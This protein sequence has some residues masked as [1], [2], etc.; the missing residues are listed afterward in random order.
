[1]TVALLYRCTSPA[2]Q[3]IRPRASTALPHAHDSSHAL[4]RSLCATAILISSSDCRS[5]TDV[6]G[7][8][9]SQ[10]PEC[11]DDAANSLALSM[12]VDWHATRPLVHVAQ[13]PIVPCSLDVCR[14]GTCRGFW[15]LDK[16]VHY[17]IIIVIFAKASGDQRP[18]IGDI[19]A[20][21]IRCKLKYKNAIKEVAVN[22]DNLF[23][24]T[25]SERELV[26]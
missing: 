1:M 23:N 20:S 18:H 9:A 4:H 17:Y 6:I 25:L 24:E 11:G 13:L 22:D 3:A 12:S 10:S 7:G 26:Q 21:R 8:A 19:N 15:P 5:P 2:G 16:E 14:L